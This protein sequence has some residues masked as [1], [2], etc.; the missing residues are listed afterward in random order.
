ML[1]SAVRTPLLSATVI[2]PCA[3]SLRIF[4]VAHPLG[5]GDMSPLRAERLHDD[6]MRR[7]RVAAVAREVFLSGERDNASMTTNF[8]TSLLTYSV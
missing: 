7:K 2:T 5:A 6:R 4:A 3:F 8:V 1:K